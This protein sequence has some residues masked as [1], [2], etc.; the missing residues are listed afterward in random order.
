VNGS[1]LI[2]AGILIDTNIVSAH[3]KGDAN[4]TP[5]LQTAPAIYVSAVVVGELYFGAERSP[6]ADR[7]QRRIEQFLGAVLVLDVEKETAR[8]Y[9]RIKAELM[10]T[11][12][13][14]PDNDLWIAAP[15]KQRDMTLISRDRHFGHVPGLKWEIW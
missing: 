2:Q 8:V 12:Q 5:R 13:M 6:N 11:G 7:N 3:F 4:V 14:I 1:S 10:T 9:G 15:A